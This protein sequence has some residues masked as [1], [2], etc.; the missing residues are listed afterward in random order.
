MICVEYLIYDD[1][2]DVTGGKYNG[3]QP[4]YGSITHVETTRP[5]RGFN[6]LSECCWIVPG[7][8]DPDA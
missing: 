2:P 4:A 3:V 1:E 5:L 7:T 8:I 6:S